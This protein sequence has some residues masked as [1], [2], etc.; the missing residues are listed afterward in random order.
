MVSPPKV[1]RSVTVMKK[2]EAPKPSADRKRGKSVAKVAAPMR[3]RDE[4]A[5]RKA[6]EK[7]TKAKRSA[8]V[9]PSS[10]SRP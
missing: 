2:K 1:I 3:K 7:V 5:A 10:A 4:K 9:A 6:D 8:T